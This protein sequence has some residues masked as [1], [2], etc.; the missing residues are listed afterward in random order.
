MATNN[1][2]NMPQ[3]GV[4]IIGDYSETNVFTDDALSSK[5]LKVGATLRTHSTPKTGAMKR[6]AGAMRCP[7]GAMKRPAGSI[8]FFAHWGGAEE[9]TQISCPPRDVFEGGM[10]L[11]VST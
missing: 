8:G 1:V 11:E 3:S 7:A 9:G 2:M 5:K 10:C 4:D 6:P